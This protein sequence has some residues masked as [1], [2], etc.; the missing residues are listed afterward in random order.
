M[1]LKSSQATPLLTE[2]AKEHFL[3]SVCI[4]LSLTLSATCSPLQRKPSP[5]AHTAELPNDIHLR[6]KIQAAPS[7]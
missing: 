2:G 3:P 7:A 4:L 6:G 1:L 5:D